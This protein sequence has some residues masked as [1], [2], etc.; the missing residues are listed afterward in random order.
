M[1][2][3]RFL[4]DHME[5]MHYAYPT[6]AKYVLHKLGHAIPVRSRRKDIEELDEQTQQNLEALMEK[7]DRLKAEIG[8]FVRE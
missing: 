2:V 5:V 3:Q 8:G 4:I 7:Y 6:S 1:D